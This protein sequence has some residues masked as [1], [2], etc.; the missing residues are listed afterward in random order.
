MAVPVPS[1]GQKRSHDFHNERSA[2]TMEKVTAQR[3]L[4][5][6][7]SGKKGKSTSAS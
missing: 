7:K 6:F 1:V 3:E 4:D 2:E 5:V